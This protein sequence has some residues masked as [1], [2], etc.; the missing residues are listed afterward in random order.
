MTM[1]ER[2]EILAEGERLRAAILD[3]DTKAS[4]GATIDER[5][6]QDAYRRSSELHDRYR[7][8]LPE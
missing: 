8:W 3:W 1:A 4:F 5:A 2:N 7:Q 6:L